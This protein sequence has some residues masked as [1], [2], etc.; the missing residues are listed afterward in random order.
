[1]VT[2]PRHL[3]P[4]PHAQADGQSY[5]DSRTAAFRPSRPIR[6]SRSTALRTVL[7]RV[8]NK[9][10]LGRA[11]FAI[12]LV[13]M[14]LLIASGRLPISLAVTLSTT[15]VGLVVLFT[16]DSRARF[17]L[18][19]FIN[20]CL[21]VVGP[22]FFGAIDLAVLGS[23]TAL[24]AAAL[25]VLFSK[26]PR[27]QAK[28]HLRSGARLN[29]SLLA[30]VCFGGIAF[31]STVA[32]AQPLIV[33]LPWLNG[34]AL[35]LLVSLVPSSSLPSFSLAR[36]AIIVAG[37]VTVAFDL[38]LLATGK[39]MN[40]GPFNS[41]R[42]LGSVGDYELL[43][44]FYGALILIALTAVFFE[45]DRRWQAI[46]VLLLIP[47][48]FVLVATESRG[49]IVLLCV[50]GPLLIATSIL[51]F[52]AAAGRIFR[53]SL[54]I[55]ITVVASLGTLA[56][57]PLFE[58]LMS[59]QF[60]GSVELT[61]NRA[62]VWDYFTHLPE[63][64]QLGPAGNGFEYPYESIGTYPHSLY[65]WLLWSAGWLG[66]GFFVVFICIELSRLA[67]G[68]AGRSSAALSAAAVL[69]FVLTDQIKIE[70]ARNSATVSFLWVVIAMAVLA[71]R[72][73]KVS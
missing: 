42:F 51:L 40:V 8:K 68:V 56:T 13:L 10:S 58:R 63:F 38:V 72:E 12:A 61:L 36:R 48:S 57:T 35:T 2:A 41:G 65:L 49:P 17:L 5:Q 33:L 30:L 29:P 27:S 23:L 21:L 59:T 19:F 11:C 53:T 60:G 67:A 34:L 3:R 54:V 55:A 37:L 28:G 64:I 25:G 69:A 26:M 71:G 46:A 9:C 39:A 52:R 45:N 7:D 50:I 70:A 22:R 31:I 1:M 15:L 16:L 4:R 14:A 66:L 20:A 62:G 32:N 43:A 6:Q 73:R 47:S 18:V 24:L 44:E